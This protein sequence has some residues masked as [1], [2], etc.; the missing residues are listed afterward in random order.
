LRTN[1]QRS[2]LSL[3]AYART[4]KRPFE[5]RYDPYTQT[6]EVLDQPKAIAKAIKQLNAEME[7]LRS[8][9]AK[10]PSLGLGV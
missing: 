8:A 10:L 2:L 7:Q 6:V 3:R 5:L 9:V 1:G 4:I